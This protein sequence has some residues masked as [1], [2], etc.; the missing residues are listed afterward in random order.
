MEEDDGTPSNKSASEQE[1]IQEE[2]NQEEQQDLPASTSPPPPAQAPVLPTPPGSESTNDIQHEP[3]QNVHVAPPVSRIPMG[4]KPAPTYDA[5]ASLSDT[6]TDHPGPRCGH[7]LTAVLAVGE[8]NS[9]GYVG[10]RLVLF[11]GATSIED[12]AQAAGPQS[13]GGGAGISKALFS[14]CSMKSLLEFVKH[15]QK[16]SICIPFW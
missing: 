2:E 15:E 6:E 10:P 12:G 8:E 3:E 5:I 11:G 13:I 4:P 9:P 14:P 16:T 7:T 1:H